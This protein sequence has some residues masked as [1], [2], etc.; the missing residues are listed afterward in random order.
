MKRNI[1]GVITAV[2][3]LTLSL[4]GCSL[5]GEPTATEQPAAAP[6]TNVLGEYALLSGYTMYQSPDGG[7]SIQ[8]PEGSTINDADLNDVTITVASAYANADMINI[9]KATGVQAVS[10]VD[11]LYNMLKD[12]N[13]IDITGFF[14]L[15][16]DG[17]YKGYKYT[18]TAMD[19]SQLKGIVSTYVGADGSAY[20]VSAVIN[21]C[22]DEQNVEMINTV[23]DTFINYL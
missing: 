21:N 11:Q 16:M 12:D 10:T 8:L 2:T 5:T 13:T 23:V 7:F 6:V 9:K 20:R 3:A 22:G 1:I 18:H 15:N 4:G 19:N 14:V 17:S